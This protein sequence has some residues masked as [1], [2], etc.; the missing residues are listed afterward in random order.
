M[1]IKSIALVCSMLLLVNCGASHSSQAVGIYSLDCLQNKMYTTYENGFW[2]YLRANGCAGCH[3]SE[4][5][6]GVPHFADGNLNKALRAFIPLGPQKIKAKLSIG[7]QS[8]NYTN[9]KGSIDQLATDWSVKQS[10][11]SC[12]DGQI[13][14][15]QSVL[16]FE[17]GATGTQGAVKSSM[18]TPQVVEW[19]LGHRVNGAKISAEISVQVEGG[20]PK[21][22]LVK[23]LKLVSPHSKVRIKNIVVLLNGDDHFNTTFKIIDATVPAGSTYVA[24]SS[25]GAA[26]F[27]EKQA[28]LY[29]NADEWKLNIETFAAVH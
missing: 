27:F 4:G 20:F 21:G 22:Y 1:L 2:N 12:E 24:I 7:H 9:M 16:F 23:N 13:T 11:S 6:A 18:L 25:N 17:P 8:Y 14:S 15:A 29:T 28:G 5:L 10:A 19:D 26:A 3:S